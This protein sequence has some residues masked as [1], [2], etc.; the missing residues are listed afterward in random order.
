M[1]DI[2][3]MRDISDVQVD[4]FRHH[5]GKQNLFYVVAPNTTTLSPHSVCSI[6]S[7]STL[8]FNVVVVFLRPVS[9]IR[10]SDNLALANAVRSNQNIKLVTIMEVSEFLQN[11]VFDGMK[12]QE[13]ATLLTGVLRLALVSKLGGNY[14]C[15]LRCDGCEKYEHFNF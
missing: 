4:T 9:Q 5:F 10:L 7:F 6:E 15:G 11:T 13:S 1:A 8:N 3:Q 12:L 2:L 14:V